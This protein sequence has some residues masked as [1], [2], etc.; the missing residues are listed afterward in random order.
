MAEEILERKDFSFRSWLAM[1]LRFSDSRP[2]CSPTEINEVTLTEK[3]WVFWMAFERDSPDWTSSSINPMTFFMPLVLT[4]C[5]SDLRALMVSVPDETRRLR[6]S[7]KNSLSPPMP[8]VEKGP[9]FFLLVF[10]GGLGFWFSIAG[11]NS[12]SK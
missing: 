9:S 3:M 6:F 8:R 1:T 7:I 12:N 2:D 10:W 11:R 5:W 4:S